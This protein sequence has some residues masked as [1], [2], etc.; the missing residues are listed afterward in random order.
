VLECTGIFNTQESASLHL[1]AGAKKVLLSAPAKSDSI[2]TIVLGV[3]QGDIKSTDKILSNA[4]CTTNCLAPLI[5]VIEEN[6]G[7]D[8]GSMTTIHAYTGDQRIQ[9]APHKDLRRARAGAYN[10]IPTSTGAAKAVTKVIKGIEGKLFA[11]AVRVPAITGSLV[12]LN[13]MLNKEVTAEKINKTFKKYSKGSLK[14]ILQYVED[15]IVSS[16][17]VRNTHSS[18]FDSGLTDVNGR[19][20]KIVSWYDNEAGYSARLA[21]LT[22]TV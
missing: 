18:I 15:P 3:N 22:A 20:A 7:L 1:K 13:V 2:K 10:I 4:S 8:Q 19:M 9:D 14:G 11:M 5:K 17:I 21:E 12:E 16:D 6:W